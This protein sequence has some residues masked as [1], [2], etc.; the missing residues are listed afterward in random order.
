MTFHQE[1]EAKTAEAA[2]EKAI[3]EL[4]IPKGELKYDVLSYGSTGIFG[5]VGVKKA[6]IRVAVEKDKKSPQPEKRKARPKKDNAAASSAQVRQPE[7]DDG[8]GDAVQKTPS[9]PEPE[10]G[11]QEP[12][13][14]IDQAKALAIEAVAAIAQSIAEDC[15]VNCKVN[16]ANEIVIDIDNERP[17]VLIGRRGQT[18]DAIQYL[19]EKVVNKGRKT[20]VRVRVDA[21]GY[22][23]RR[24]KNLARQALRLCEKVKKSGKPASF[25]PMSAHD[26]RIVH[27]ALQNDHAVRTQSKGTGYMRKL[28]IFPQ[29]NQKESAS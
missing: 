20:K 21:G 3:K 4:N 8:E 7:Q 17:A 29:K 12:G 6:K 15:S 14:D 1:F 13:I 9:R 11:V 5:L 18:L 10:P 26:R 2:V 25:S 27:M 28:V 23:A 19:A 22:L 24:K 16:G